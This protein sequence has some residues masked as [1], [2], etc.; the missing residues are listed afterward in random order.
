MWRT[1]PPFDHQFRFGVAS[2]EDNPPRE[3]GTDIFFPEG[4]II[5]FRVRAIGDRVVE[6]RRFPDA[7]LRMNWDGEPLAEVSDYALPN[8][9]AHRLGR[10]IREDLA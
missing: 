8:D 6:V 7:S 5:A 9:L 1:N 4:P 2:Q 10:I 3:R